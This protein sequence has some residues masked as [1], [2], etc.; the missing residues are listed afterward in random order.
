MWTIRSASLVLVLVA[1]C[2]APALAA[3]PTPLE[4]GKEATASVA[5]EGEWAERSRAFRFEVPADAVQA[6]LDLDGRADV[7]LTVSREPLAAQPKDDHDRGRGRD[8]DRDPGVAR[9]AGTGGTEKVIVDRDGEPAL[10]TGTYYATVAYERDLPPHQAGGKPLEKVEFRLRLAL[11]KTRTDGTLDAAGKPASGTIDPKEGGFRTYA[12]DVPDGAKVLRLDLTDAP[13]DLN[14]RARRGKPC[15]SAA[16]AD[17][18]AEATTATEVLLIE[19]DD[20][21]NLAGKWFVDVLD[22]LGL[23]F[24]VPFKL[25]ASLKAEPDP[26]ILAFPKAP[27]PK[28]PLERSIYSTVEL[29]DDEGGGSGVLISDRGWIITNYHVVQEEVEGK[30]L[31]GDRI[32]VGLT[33]DPR[34]PPHEAFKARVVASDPDLDLALLKCETGMYDQPIPADYRFPTAAIGAAEKLSLGDSLFVVGYP[35]AGGLGSKVSVTFTRGVVAGFERRGSTLH[36]KTDAEINS[37]NSGG[38]VYDQRFE[39]IGFATETIGDEGEGARGQIGYIR[40][41]WL[42]PAEWWTKA[43]VKRP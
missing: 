14:L 24:T 38:G 31:V 33:I 32:V 27:Q 39:V 40:P 5:S 36:I 22:P 11:I 2:A 26:S 16:D 30:G 17:A 42:V 3:D 23:E 20:E 12:V 18:T 10:E 25:R 9:S 21:G 43:G 35:A 41:V 19:G 28:S 4:P 7:N 13:A 37:G 8:R 6:R 29:I 34:D 15:V 1:L